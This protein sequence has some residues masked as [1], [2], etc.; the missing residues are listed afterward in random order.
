[1]RL[2]VAGLFCSSALAKFQNLDSFKEL[3]ARN[4]LWACGFANII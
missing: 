2:G 3:I 4:G 1:M